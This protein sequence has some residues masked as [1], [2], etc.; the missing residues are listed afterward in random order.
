MSNIECPTRLPSRPTGG[1][2][3]VSTS[4]VSSSITPWI[5]PF[6]VLLLLSISQTQAAPAPSNATDKAVAAVNT[7]FA[8]SQRAA[9]AC[10]MGLNALKNAMAICHL[11]EENLMGAL[12]TGEDAKIRYAREAW[13][14][15]VSEIDATLDATQQII[16]HANDSVSAHASARD[17]ATLASKAPDAKEAEKA[18]RKAEKFATAAE[19]AAKAAESLAEVLKKKWLIP[20]PVMSPPIPAPPASTQSPA[21]AKAETR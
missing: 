19:K 18:A 12:K 6:F 20:S 2:R 10:E 16:G 11:Q 1:G 3:Q 7:A 9:I 5:L 13:T 17:Q 15:A 8:S 14:K 4:K 21:D